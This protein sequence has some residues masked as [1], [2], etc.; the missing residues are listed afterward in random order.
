MESS[1]C[2]PPLFD[3]AYDTVAYRSYKM[4][5]VLAKEEPEPQGMLPS[6]DYS[7]PYDKKVYL[8]N[9][10]VALEWLPDEEY[11][12]HLRRA[13]RRASDFLYDVTDGLMAFGQVVFGGPELMAGADIQIM[14]SNRFFPRSWVSALHEADKFIPIRMG[15][16][17]WHGR[18]KFTIGWDEAE[19]YRTIIHEWM[20]YALGLKDQ[21]LMNVL[22]HENGT[23]F[24]RLREG[25]ELSRSSPLLVV[26]SFSIKSP[27]IMGTPVGTSELFEQAL[28]RAETEIALDLRSKIQD[29]EWLGGP[30]QFPLPLPHFYD[31]LGEA[32]VSIQPALCELPDNLIAERFPRERAWVYLLKPNADDSG[33]RRLVPQGTLDNLW[34]RERFSFQQDVADENKFQIRDAEEGDRVVLIADNRSFTKILYAA[35]VREVDDKLRVLTRDWRMIRETEFPALA[36]TPHLDND[37]MRTTHDEATA[38]DQDS[39]A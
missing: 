9:V 17:L 25:E 3:P 15:R 18:N 13:F 19:G 20:H 39:P 5:R 6:A 30:T 23:H 8:F 12:A 34:E 36:V 22:M 28:G 31:R 14:V 4:Y 27:S 32:S 21:Y 11:L 2:R 7:V 35:T 10:V 1:T 33:F 29:Q 26:P 16:G 37:E 24:R 38:T